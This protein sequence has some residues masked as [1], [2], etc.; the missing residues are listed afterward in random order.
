M[1]QHL[2]SLGQNFLV[3][4]SIAIDIVGFLDVFNARD[5]VVEIGP[6]DGVLTKYLVKKYSNLYLVELDARLVNVLRKRY[7]AISD[8]IMEADILSVNF[9]SCWNGQKINF[10]TNLPY[11]ISG[12]FVF[13]LV[14]YRDVVR[15]AVC[16]LQKEVAERLVANP[17]TKNYGIPSVLLQAYFDVRVLFDVSSDNFYP[18]PSVESTVIK[19]TRNGIDKLDC[20]EHMFD[21]VVHTAFQQ[22]R[23]MIRNSLRQYGVIDCDLCRLRP[24][25]MT[26]DDFVRI[27][28][29]IS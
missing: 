4:E 19:I 27:T 28:Q 8:R 25:Q 5:L 3:N 7:P 24:E 21:K 16:M 11:N 22:R 6:G 12:P 18:K 13:K 29:I 17:N 26:V 9:S 1:F 15:Q 2:K 20:D 10:V 14:E 23:K